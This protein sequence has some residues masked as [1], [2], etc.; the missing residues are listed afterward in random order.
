MRCWNQKMFNTPLNFSWAVEVGSATHYKCLHTNALFYWWL[1]VLALAA[2]QSPLCPPIVVV[3]ALH[4]KGWQVVQA[5]YY[6]NIGRFLLLPLDRSTNE[7]SLTTI[8]STL[9]QK[10]RKFPRNTSECIWEQVPGPVNF[11]RR[12]N[13]S[14][15]GNFP[16]QLTV[17]PSEISEKFREEK[18]I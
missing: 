9:S 4:S 5:F 13:P 12:F 1:L 18:K 2:S 6:V 11:R 8:T 17:L 15:F 14:P 16:K 3:V 7:N 10:Q